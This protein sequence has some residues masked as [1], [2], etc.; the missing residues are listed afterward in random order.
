MRKL[1]YLLAVVA[2][3]LGS[4]LSATNAQNP[5]IIYRDTCIKKNTTKNQKN[6][7]KKTNSSKKTNSVSKKQN[8]QNQPDAPAN[9]KT[10][11]KTVVDFDTTAIQS[12]AGI[13]I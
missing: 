1:I 13:A 10:T 2:L 4:C 3:Y 7:A 11:K 8:S 6:V 5:G 9:T 12:G